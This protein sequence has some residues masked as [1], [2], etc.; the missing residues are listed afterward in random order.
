MDTV[1][2]KTRSR[3]MRAVRDADTSPEMAVRR[4]LHAAGYR[5]WLHAKELPGKPDIVFTKKRK[6]IFVHGC[7]WHQHP[8]C[9]AADRPRSNTDYWNAKLDRN[10]VR[11]ERSRS[12]LSHA[13]WSVHVVWECE[14]ND[15]TG[16]RARLLAFLGPPRSAPVSGG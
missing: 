1:N 8:G 7:F 6:V 5:Y 16:V 11:D 15:L 3:T 12:A 9:P 13:G 10:V 14:L 4:L 2:T